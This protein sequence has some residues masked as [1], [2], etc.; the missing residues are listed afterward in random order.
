MAVRVFFII[1]IYS[2]SA[3]E[4]GAQIFTLNTKD[5]QVKSITIP[6]STVQSVRRKG[7]VVEIIGEIERNQKGVTFLPIVP[8]S[9]DE[10]YEVWN[11]KSK[12][13]EFTVK[14]NLSVPRLINVYPLSNEV[15]ANFLKFYLEFSNS[16][17]EVNPY[18]KISLY[19]GNQKL[20]HAIL[21]L[22]PPLWNEDRTVLTVW[23][24]PG[25]IKTDLGPNRMIGSILKPADSIEI[26][27]EPLRG[28]NALKMDSTYRKRIVILP[29]DEIKPSIQNWKL[30]TPV[31]SSTEQLMIN[32]LEVMDYGSTVSGIKILYGGKDFSGSTDFVNDTTVSFKPDAKWKSGSYIL[33]VNTKVEDLAGNNFNRLFE[34]DLHGNN[35]IPEDDAVELE[36]RIE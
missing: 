24:E 11:S 5:E 17:G 30:E 18:E 9:P 21:R 19:K 6:D 29:R 13:F 15:P 3:Q 34:E 14:S 35:T 10:S 1:L 25:R 23:L 8:F 27:I 22:D 28:M 7:S 16:M 26:L 31:V 33:R 4:L 2:L 36:F 12:L 20:E 32:T